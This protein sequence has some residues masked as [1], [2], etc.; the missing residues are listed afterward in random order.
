MQNP[1][2]LTLATMGP[3][4]ESLVIDAETEKAFLVRNDDG[5]GTDNDG[6]TAWI[7]KSGMTITKDQV[8]PCKEGPARFV[9]AELKPWFIRKM[10]RR[11]ARTINLLG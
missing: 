7:P 3:R 10:D 1:T 9:N 8:T 2:F 11:Q 5:S 4:I 6:W